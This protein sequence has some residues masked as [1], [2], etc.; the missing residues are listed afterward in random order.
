MRLIEHPIS[1]SNTQMSDE[2]IALLRSRVE[3]KYYD[4]PQVI[5]VI[6]RVI[7]ISRGIYL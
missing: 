2:F 1:N 6:A 5:E 3:A 7:L 4:Q